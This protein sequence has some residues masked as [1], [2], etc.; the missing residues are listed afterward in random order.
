APEYVA[1][2]SHELAHQMAAGVSFGA[3]RV[4]D[5]IE[6]FKALCADL[7]T[8]FN[9]ACYARTLLASGDQRNAFKVLTDAADR[10]PLDV[11]LAVELATFFHRIG[12]AE[13]ANVAL[14]P[15]RHTFLED[16]EVLKPAQED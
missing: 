3:G 11:N 16:R 1:G 2:R 15:V 6:G 5:G 4:D 9:F 8:A 12:D 13:A 14:D 7:P 10:Y